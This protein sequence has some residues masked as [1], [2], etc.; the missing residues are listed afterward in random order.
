MHAYA[1]SLS[2]LSLL[3]SSCLRPAYLKVVAVVRARLP[4]AHV[5]GFT[6]TATESTVNSILRSMGGGLL[7]T[8]RKTTGLY[9]RTCLPCTYLPCTYLPTLYLPA[10]PVTTYL[11]TYLPCSYTSAA[12]RGCP[13]IRVH[14]FLRL[15]APHV[16]PSLP[17]S[18]DS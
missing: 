3:F 2:R 11:P 8:R 16:A 6:G 14:S 10:Y 17:L 7:F 9:L 4:W 1:L 13:H 12:T 5:A 18:A 15:L